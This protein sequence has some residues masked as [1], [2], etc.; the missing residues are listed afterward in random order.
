MGLQLGFISMVF[1]FLVLKWQHVL[2]D[3]LVANLNKLLIFSNSEPFFI[4]DATYSQPL[5]WLY[6]GNRS[7]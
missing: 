6:L 3:L 4:V 2:R 5:K 1:A 7:E